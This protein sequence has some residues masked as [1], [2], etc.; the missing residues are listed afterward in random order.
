M[1]DRIHDPLLR[2]RRESI[3]HVVFRTKEPIVLDF[4]HPDYD[5]AQFV[6]FLLMKSFNKMDGCTPFLLRYDF[7]NYLTLE[8]QHIVRE[9]INPLVH[10]D[11]YY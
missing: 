7:L 2:Y 8:E 5:Y 1:A 10:F 6:N 3:V 9:Y 11:Y 4:G